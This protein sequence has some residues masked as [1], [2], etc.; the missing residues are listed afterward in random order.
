MYRRVI[1]FIER[2][3]FLQAYKW[4]DSLLYNIVSIYSA[5]QQSAL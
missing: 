3:I 5:I 1:Y 2:F 4:L